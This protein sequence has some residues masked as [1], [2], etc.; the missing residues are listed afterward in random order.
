MLYLNF[1][2]GAAHGWGVCG[3]QVARELA[4]LTDVRLLTNPFDAEHIGDEVEARELAALLPSPAEAQ[5]LDLRRPLKLD[6][7][8]L[9][10]ANKQ[11]EPM[12]ANLSGSPTL[13]YCF[14]EDTELRPAHVESG[15]RHFDRL[16][17]GS[18]W[19]SETLRRHGIENVA[20]VLQGVDTA[21]FFPHPR[22]AGG[23]QFL[24]DKFVVFSGG[25]FE[26]RKG[27]DLVIRAFKALQDRHRD[28]VLVASWF[29]QWRFSFQSMSQSPHIRFAPTSS[30]M[31]TAPAEVLAQNGVDLNRVILVGPRAHHAMAQVYH[32]TDVGLFPNRAEGGTNLVMM[33]YMACGK[34]VIA[35]ASTGHADVVAPDHALV[36]D[37][38]GEVVSTS[39]GE[40]VARWPE[41]DL[42]QTIARLEWAYQNRAA[43]A[44]LAARGAAKMAAMSWSR[45]AEAFLE[46]LK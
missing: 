31:T 33:E 10:L 3:R 15:R 16:A 38:G 44:P 7:P 36:I 46:L 27:Q 40:S 20:T 21:A 11:L 25:K 23:R 5:R 30:D 41:P 42:E 29:N 2:V 1:P 26:F 45:T 9:Q 17:T 4:R 34:P 32:N 28:V 18:T 22:G 19:C 35:T 8:L 24:R 43:L 6:V 39:D 14:F 13:G 37:T 12:T